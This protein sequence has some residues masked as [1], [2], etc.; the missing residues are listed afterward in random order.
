MQKL[1]TILSILVIISGLVGCASP[2]TKV[3]PTGAQP[4]VALTRYATITLT[5]TVTST[6]VNAPTATLAP[7]QTPTPR[8][9][10]VKNSDTM[11]VIAF[12]NGLTL[13]EL[14]AANPDV[15][16]NMMTVGMT[17][18]IPAPSHTSAT[19]AAPTPTPVAIEV[20]KAECHPTTTGGTLCFAMVTNTQSFDIENI[21]AEFRLTNPVNGEVLTQ[22]ATLP[23]SRLTAGSAV[24]FFAYFSPNVFANPQ[25]MLQVHTAM[26]ASSDATLKTIVN[27]PAPVIQIAPD[28]AMASV[29][30]E[31]TVDA[32]GSDAGTVWITAAAFG[33]QG[34]ILGIRRI[35]LSDGLKAGQSSPFQL[36]VYSSAG[37]I[38]S[39]ELYTDALP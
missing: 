35:E 22:P 20:E 5:P 23:V 29:S 24:P 32:G 9:Y 31:F 12:R 2:S 8:A 33:A 30:G 18:Y 1:R 37:K 3:T 27:I 15:N 19:P 14:K 6:P 17:I 21:S 13:D 16:P 28:G 39:V 4:V 34:E 11:I 7:T 25:V 38:T 10:T 26:Q 36:I